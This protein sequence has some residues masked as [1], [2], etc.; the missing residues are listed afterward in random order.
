LIDRLIV[1]VR[2]GKLYLP[3]SREKLSEIT[4]LNKLKLRA[5]VIEVE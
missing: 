1:D 3:V 4:G 5:K 2:E